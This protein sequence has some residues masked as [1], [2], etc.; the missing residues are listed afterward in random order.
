MWVSY[1]ELKPP[2]CPFSSSL[3]S[4]SAPRSAARMRAIWRA[5]QCEFGANIMAW[6]ST[7]VGPGPMKAGAGKEAQ[8]RYEARD[9]QMLSER[10][11]LCVCTQ[12]REVFP[13]RPFGDECWKRKG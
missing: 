12:A 7:T 3:T 8:A 4:V 1:R 2:V 5:I 9:R 6:A 13:A 11:E 10:P